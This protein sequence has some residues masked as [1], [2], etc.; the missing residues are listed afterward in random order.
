MRYVAASLPLILRTTLWA[1]LAAMLLLPGS[2]TEARSRPRPPRTFEL[3]YA[4]SLTDVNDIV[5][6]WPEATLI[7]Y[8]NGTLDVFDGGSGEFWPNAGT[9]VEG[10]RGR[11]IEFD[12]NGGTVY[13]GRLQTDGWY[14]GTMISGSPSTAGLTGVWTGRFTP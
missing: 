9:Y 12:L 14:D 10:R 13:S 1:F 8:D 2:S 4:W 3:I 7:L 11:T 6:G 5:P